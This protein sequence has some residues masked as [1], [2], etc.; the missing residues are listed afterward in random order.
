MPGPLEGL[1]IIE[2]AGIGPGPFAGMMFA[3]HGAEVITVHRP[4][5]PLDP[6]D[7][8]HR[9]R[10]TIA[11]DLKNETDLAMV[12]DLIKTADGLI[13]AF[14]PG[15]IERMGLGPDVL[16]QDNPKLVIG[17]ITGWGQNGPMS[18]AAGHDINYIAL[19]G[20]LHTFGRK[21]QKP[22][23]PANVV[24]D[25]GGGAMMLV[26]AMMAALYKAAQTG[27]GD[28][29]DCSMTEGS[30]LLMSTIWTFQQTHGWQHERGVNLL[31]SGAPFYDT[32]ET[33]DGEYVAVGALE[34][35]FFRLLMD[36]LGHGDDPCI[37]DHF[38]KK[39]WPH[40][41]RLLTDTFLQKT[42]AEWCDLLEGTDV[43]FSPVLSI[44]NAHT[45]P[46]NAKRDAFIKIDGM[47]QPAPTPTYLNASISPPRLPVKYMKK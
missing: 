18:H 32:Y 9:S 5:T 46:Q 45:H 11:A 30:A 2:L 40:I 15:V 42:Q 38:N 25:F 19:S 35:D 8:A 13:E 12:R 43:C 23:P 1:R 14:R 28:V 37:E 27:Q 31:D 34:P 10:E 22:T 36:K 39:H 21:G 33:A 26:F 20:A 24:A 7:P 3:D 29:V 4:D 47:R 17:R 44:E 6:R 41:A 16:W